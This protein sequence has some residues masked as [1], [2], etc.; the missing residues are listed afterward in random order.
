MPMGIDGCGAPN[1]ALPLARLA[2]AYARLAVAHDEQDDTLALLRTAMITHPEMV[3]GEGR[4]D[5]AL[6][7]AAP[8][9]W[10][11][12]GGAEG[13]QALGI[14]SRGLGIAIKIADGG[15]R[16]LRVAVSAVIA[17]LNLLAAARDGVIDRWREEEILNHAGQQ[18]GRLLPVFDLGWPARVSGVDRAIE[19]RE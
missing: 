16:A 6:M 19:G 3:A 5:L 7:R 10:V 9:D 14:R 8:G 13:V 18:T 11:A 12:K 4:T 17:R 1:Y 2:H 15:V